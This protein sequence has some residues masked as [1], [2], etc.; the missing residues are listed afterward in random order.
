MPRYAV[1]MKGLDATRYSHDNIVEYN[2]IRNTNLETTDTGAIEMLG[3]E[4]TD[5]GNVIQYN[6]ILDT[7]GLKT[8]DDGEILSPHMTWG[9]Y[10]DD[11]ASGVTVRGNLVARADWGGISVHGGK[12]NVIE[13]NVFV[14][15]NLHQIWYDPIDGFSVNNRFVRNIVFFQSESANLINAMR[16]PPSQVLSESNH[17][18]FWNTN[19]LEVFNAPKLT[20]LGNFEQWRAGGF[21]QNS[22]IADP[23]FTNRREDN[24]RLATNS[25]AFQLGFQE[26]PYEQMGLAGFARSYN[27]R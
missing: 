6:R 9:I 22:I 13:N 1:S 14:D 23:L 3:R 25:P 20:P 5:S 16:H 11:Y 27:S 21:D 12:N 4:K 19:G 10:L 8:N 26:L 2:D 15:S 7:V 18:L 17:T 24:Y